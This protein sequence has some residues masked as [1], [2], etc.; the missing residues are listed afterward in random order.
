MKL[1]QNFVKYFIRF[2]G[3][4]FQEEC[5]WD[6]LTFSEDYVWGQQKKKRKI[7]CAIMRLPSWHSP[8][9]KRGILCNT[10]INKYERIVKWYLN[11][12]ESDKK[13]YNPTGQVSSNFLHYQSVY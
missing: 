13:I 12:T 9:N 5:F 8:K 3:L 10:R 6:L 11:E 7:I 4:E 1:G 2:L